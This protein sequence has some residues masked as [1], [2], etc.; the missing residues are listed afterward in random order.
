MPL[1]QP[2]P[3][4]NNAIR[5]LCLH[6]Y[7]TAFAVAARHRVLLPILL[8]LVLASCGGGNSSV[9]STPTAPAPTPIPS[10]TTGLSDAALVYLNLNLNTLANYAA[11]TLPAHYD[12]DVAVQDNTPANNIASDKVATLGRVLFFDK[13]LSINNT[14]ACASCH[15]AANGF[16]DDTRFSVGFSGTA[17]TTAHAMRLGNNRYYRPGTMF[18]DKRAAS[19]ETQASQPL[20]NAVE[21]GWAASAGGIPA[22]LTKMSSAAP[23]SS[24]Y[25]ELFKFA[26]GDSAITE[27]RV[28]KALAQFERSMISANSKWDTAYAGVYSATAPNKGIGTSLLSRGFT[29]SEE[30]GRTLFMAPPQNGGLG[31]V[32]CHS[33]PTFA[34]DGNSRGNGLDITETHIFKSP[35]LKNAALDT[36]FMHDGR[37]ATLEAVIEHY[38][39]GVQASP[40]LDNRL[41][42][43]AGNPRRLNLI[44]ADKTALV[45]FLKTLNDSVLVS[46]TR[47]VSPFKP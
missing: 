46:D 12:A 25:P 34:L 19:V 8:P 14:V 13:R 23:T 45:D 5:R 11:P 37:F 24:Y 47:F 36:A 7:I 16:G 28:Q 22:L 40:V 31:C 29:A 43:A 18:W 35:S 10:N 1:D 17:F 33:A 44:A 27:D 42:D 15:Q 38:N 6:P 32:G 39:S 26:F 41:K 21:M 20:M 3:A 2:L 9:A 30:R 4:S